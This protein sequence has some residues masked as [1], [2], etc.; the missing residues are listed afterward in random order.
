MYATGQSNTS[1]L[2]STAKPGS[3]AVQSITVDDGLPQGFINSIVQDNQGFIWMSTMDGLARYDGRSIKVFKNNPNDSTSLAA[4]VLTT[5][6]IDRENNIWIVYGNGEV[7]LLNPY[8]EVVRHI[9]REPNFSWMFKKFIDY[10]F[11][12]IEDSHHEFWIIYKESDRER[13]LYHFNFK[14]PLPQNIPF[15]EDEAAFAL[16]ED[17]G[18]VWLLTN[19]SLYKLKD[20]SLKKISSLPK[21]VSIKQDY[22]NAIK[23]DYFNAIG[24]M[25]RDIHNDWIIGGQGYI[26][27]YNEQKNI[28]QLINTE[29]RINRFFTVSSDGTVYCNSDVNLCC[30]NPD[31]TLSIVW[32][33]KLGG[34]MSIMT[35]RSNVLWIGTNTFGARLISLTSRGF[36]SF[37]YEYGFFNDV[38]LKWLHIPNDVSGRHGF[39]SQYAFRT[40]VDK[41][42]NLW[43]TNL[44]SYNI[45]GQ[46]WTATDSVYLFKLS[47]GRADVCAIKLNAE[48]RGRLMQSITFDALNRCWGVSMP[49][50]FQI[51]LFHKKITPVLYLKYSDNYAAYITASGN[52]LCIVFNHGIVLYDTL[53]KKTSVYPV[54]KVFKNTDLLMATADP[55]NADVVWVA[56]MG[57]GLIRFDTKTGKARAF[58]EKDGIPNNTVYAIVADKHGFLWCSSNKSIFRFNPEDSSIISFTAKDG[59]QGNEFNR[60]HFVDL[61]DGHIIFGGTQGWTVFHPDSIRIDQFQPP[62]AVTEI[63]VN[64]TPINQLPGWKDSAV[65]AM[66]EL[67]LPYNRNFLTFYFSGLEFNEPAKMQYRYRLTGIDKDWV[68]IGNRNIANYTNLPPGSYTFKVNAT[69]TSDI[70]SNKITTIEI[71]IL[72]PWWRTWWAYG[73]FTA[74]VFTAA[75]A[76]YRSRIKLIR[77]KQET[78]LKQKEAEQLRAVDEMKSRFF[79]NITHEFRTPLTLIIAPLEELNKDAATPVVVKNKLS[80]IQRNARQLARLINQLL[81]LSKLE[82]GNMKISLSRGELQLFIADCVQSFEQIVVSKQVHLHFE[83]D[84]VNGEYLFDAGKLEKI[85]F[86]LLSNAIKFTPPGGEVKVKLK[87]IQESD[88]K[89]TLLLQVSDSGIGIAA[90]QLTKIFTRFYQVDA[91]STRAYE[92][93]GIGLALTKELTELMGGSIRVESTPGTG[94]TFHVTI[95]V[96]IATDQQVPLWSGNYSAPESVQVPI[97]AVKQAVPAVCTNKTLILIVEDNKELLAFI[98]GALATNYRVLTAENGEEGL[99]TAREELP[100]IIVSDVMMPEM[101][102][103]ELCRLIKSDIKTSHIAFII[104]TAKASHDSVIEGLMHSAD[105]YITK[106]FHIDE[107]QLRVRNIL[108]HQEKIRQHHHAQLTNPKEP[109]DLQTEEDGFLKQLYIIIE[110]NI[111]DSSL[112]VEKLAREMAVSRRTLNR[113]LSVLVGGLSANDVVKQYRLKKAAELLKGG[114]KIA[115]IAYRVGFETPAYFSTSFKNFYGVPPSEYLNKVV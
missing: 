35:D 46:K 18:I 72:P 63:F 113:K 82:A 34:F 66:K 16:K 4:S 99:K 103:Y 68:R 54:E 84:A 62:A 30:L 70:W 95:P 59:L 50:L 48:D 15:P 38:L 51:D 112:N 23:Q 109:I 33:S 83:V 88:G 36:R 49:K 86:N 17:K 93:T 79:S 106:P 28:W 52:K 78:Q 96:Q 11:G 1:S 10:P 22:F 45:D 39:F 75:T 102:G 57:G 56:S 67:S 32:V 9:S 85:V 13:K 24:N 74:I 92:G 53:T 58:T 111:D 42:G 21:P 8:T 73:L 80:I 41:T 105:D 76:F 94:T 100:D 26:Q 44:P 55:K 6:A 101:D 25:V 2:L 61:P 7:D 69:N 47:P 29:G 107:L 115:D 14:H 64:N 60:Y 20:G 19:S 81:D 31:H 43:G 108:D 90:D 110:E 89:H 91:T 5:I 3:M 12:L 87:V 37:P 71:I 40:A 114:Y 98:A 104:L 97:A 77:S 27:I 65:S